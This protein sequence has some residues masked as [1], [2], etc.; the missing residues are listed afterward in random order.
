[1]WRNGLIC[2]ERIWSFSRLC[3]PLTKKLWGGMC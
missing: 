3:V 1:M 2:D